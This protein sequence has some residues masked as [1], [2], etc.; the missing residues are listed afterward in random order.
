VVSTFRFTELTIRGLCVIDLGAKAGSVDLLYVANVRPGIEISTGIA[1]CPIRFGW[2]GGI[3]VLSHC[4]GSRT[5][6]DED[7]R[8][9]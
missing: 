2:V 1:L 3:L 9:L 8:V 6:R 7:C 5:S 4:V